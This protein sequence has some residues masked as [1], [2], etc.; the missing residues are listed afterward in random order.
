MAKKTYMT[1]EEIMALSPDDFRD[2]SPDEDLH[3]NF[4]RMFQMMGLIYQNQIDI[5][6]RLDGNVGSVA[7]SNS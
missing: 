2:L 3:D 6:N 1:E 7:G 4:R 5:K